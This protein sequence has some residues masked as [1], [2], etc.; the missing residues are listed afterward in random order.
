MHSNSQ[1]FT[2][3]TIFLV[4]FSH[5]KI[6]NISDRTHFFCNHDEMAVSLN[7]VPPPHDTIKDGH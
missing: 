5:N 3:F 2:I 4:N 1:L 6:L 7:P